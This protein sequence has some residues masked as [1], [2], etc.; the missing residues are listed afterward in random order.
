MLTLHYYKFQ[1]IETMKRARQ[2]DRNI[3]D[4][5][6]LGQWTG[7]LNISSLFGVR[8]PKRPKRKTSLTP[9][10]E[11]QELH[12]NISKG[13]LLMFL[14]HLETFSLPKKRSSK[15]TCNILFSY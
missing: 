11:S 1:T 3:L 2:G 5:G 12:L 9:P 15:R 13:C 6:V 10:S 7:K 4:L 14:T 8:V